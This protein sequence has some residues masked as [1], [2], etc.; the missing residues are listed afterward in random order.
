MYWDFED[1]MMVTLIHGK[2]FMG[3]GLVHDPPSINSYSIELP[4]Y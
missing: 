4:V 2:R 1:K 3:G